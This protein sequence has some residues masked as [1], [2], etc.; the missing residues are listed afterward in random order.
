MQL[1]YL[2]SDKLKKFSYNILCYSYN[3]IHDI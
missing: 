1:G 3:N 2:Q